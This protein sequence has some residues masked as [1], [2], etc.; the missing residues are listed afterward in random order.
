MFCISVQ[1]CMWYL[2]SETG[3][4]IWSDHECWV[5]SLGT[6]PLA[7]SFRVDPLH[8]SLNMCSWLPQMHLGKGATAMTHG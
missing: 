5:Y 8:S 2:T 4:Y 6:M 1:Q 3:H 7:A